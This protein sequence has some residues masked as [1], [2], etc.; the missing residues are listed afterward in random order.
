[1]SKKNKII[2]MSECSLCFAKFDGSNVP[3]SKVLPAKIMEL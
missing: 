1:M 2:L 3:L